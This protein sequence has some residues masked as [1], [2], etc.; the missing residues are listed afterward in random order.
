MLY[1]LHHGS[2]RSIELLPNFVESIILDWSLYSDIL[3]TLAIVIYVLCFKK[4]KK[5]VEGFMSVFFKEELRTHVLQDMFFLVLK[6][7]QTWKNCWKVI[8]SS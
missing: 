5:P 2:R 3:S 4:Q 8:K 1:L 6:S 7:I